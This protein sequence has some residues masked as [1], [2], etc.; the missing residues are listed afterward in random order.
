MQ[1][2]GFSIVELL[3][4]VRVCGTLQLDKCPASY[5]SDYLAVNLAASNPALAAKV[6]RLSEEALETLGDCLL[7]V[8]AS[9][10]ADSFEAAEALTGW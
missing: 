9:L 8:K 2:V 1:A 10:R 4:L 7:G 6:R 3:Q 5:L